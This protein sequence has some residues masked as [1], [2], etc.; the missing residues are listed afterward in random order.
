M[1]IGIHL[2]LYSWENK[3]YKSF[4]NQ[5]LTGVINKHKTKRGA[6]IT[7]GTPVKILTTAEN[8]CTGVF[9]ELFASI[10]FVIAAFW[11]ASSVPMKAAFWFASKEAI[12]DCF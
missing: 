9:T 2:H 6:S 4:G 8:Y 10:A 5:K 3:I 11:F 1:F 12:T 7:T